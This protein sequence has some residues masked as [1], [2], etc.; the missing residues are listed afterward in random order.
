LAF[1]GLAGLADSQADLLSTGQARLVELGRAIVTRP[2]VLLLDEPA[3]GL[4][5]HET[6][7][8]IEMLAALAES[9]VAVLLVEHDMEVVMAACGS[10]HVID[11]GRLLAVGSPDEVRANQA[12]LDA[13]LGTS[14]GTA[15]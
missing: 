12:V 5:V 11:F 3:S 9:G 15:S 4:D 7:G 10:I 8:F 6:G 14:A 13:Y 2:K 1:V